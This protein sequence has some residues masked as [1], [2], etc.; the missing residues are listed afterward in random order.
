MA[1]RSWRNRRWVM[2]GAERSTMQMQF[3]IRRNAASSEWKA[4]GRRK[5]FI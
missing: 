2:F 1:A 5:K 4:L 3:E